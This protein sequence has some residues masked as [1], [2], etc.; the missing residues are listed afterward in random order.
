M[1]NRQLIRAVIRWIELIAAIIAVIGA[2]FNL[3]SGWPFNRLLSIWDHQI[4]K[5]SSSEDYRI[6]AL[7]TSSG[8]ILNPTDKFSYRFHL[9]LEARG[10]TKLEDSANI[11]VVLQDENH[12]YYLQSPPVQIKNGEWRSHKI[13]PLHGIKGIIWLKVDA[14]GHSFFLRKQDKGEWGKF[15]DLPSHS[16]EVSYIDLR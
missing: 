15:S 7:K 6:E 13:F 4:L 10:V 12:C 2:I 16:T 3:F 11:W 8:R 1:N 5:I 9:P 14:E